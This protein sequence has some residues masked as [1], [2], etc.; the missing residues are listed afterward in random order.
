M[1]FVKNL[2]GNTLTFDVE[3][4]DSVDNL[5]I[6][7]QE[8]E[9]IS[10]KQQRLIFAGMQLEDGRT[11][12]DYKIIECSTLHLVLRLLGMISNFKY[13]NAADPLDK[14]LL[15]DDEEFTRAPIPLEAL[16]Q[17]VD[18]VDAHK[19][20][21]NSYIYVENNGV[22]ED[23]HIQLLNNFVLYVRE[24]MKEF[25]DE[26][27]DLR[28]M[29]DDELFQLLLDSDLTLV[30]SLKKI[31]GDRNRSGCKFILRTTEGPLNYC[32]HFH[33]D[34]GYA[35]KTIQIPLNDSYKGGK[36]CFFID[37]Q[38]FIPPRI[39]GSMTVHEAKVL[40]GVTSVQE[41]IRNSFFVVDQTNNLEG[42]I[43]IKRETVEAYNNRK[44]TFE[45]KI[46][47]LKKE[48]SLLRG[49]FDGSTIEAMNLSEIEELEKQLN[50]TLSKTASRRAS[51]HRK[52]ERDK[53]CSVC[54]TNDKCVLLM[55]C[56]HLCV[57]E[58]CSTRVDNCPLCNT[59]ATNKV[60]VLFNNIT[61]LTATYI[62]STATF[63]LVAVSDTRPS[64]SHKVSTLEPGISLKRKK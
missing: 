35:T 38:I 63:P 28:M 2:T 20:N 12:S 44:E 13:N 56:N 58:P 25:Q 62:S 34:G 36:L 24:R 22:L 15:L 40:H 61:D 14:Y 7:I 50:A 43:E 26:I 60:K 18:E 3:L 64:L 57:C 11:L 54:V 37:D 29:I 53:L 30:E 41:G 16:R 4:S 10:P 48:L 8:K 1:I 23:I 19:T 55:P 47:L 27:P 49:K 52:D 17:K 33:I 45:F 46:S 42:V 51:I 39:P 31:H 21:E 9:G 6:K 5:K 59:G 32:I